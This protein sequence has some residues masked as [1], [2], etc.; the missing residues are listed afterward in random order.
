VRDVGRRLQ[1]AEVWVYF[2]GRKLPQGGLFIYNHAVLKVDLHGDIEAS[3]EI[4]A[5]ALSSHELHL[6]AAR[7][8]YSSGAQMESWI[9]IGRVGSSVFGEASSNQNL[10]E[11]SRNGSLDKLIAEAKI[12]DKKPEPIPALKENRPKLSSTLS[13]LAV[14]PTVPANQRASQAFVT[15][16]SPTEIA[17]HYGKTVLP[18]GTRL[19]LVSRDGANVNAVYLDETVTIPVSSTDLR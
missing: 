13:V 17:T 15:L 7:R 3:D 6:A 8:H 4:A 5:P 11:A 2:V 14:S 19:R 18:P 16:T 12:R 10:L 1:N 9:A